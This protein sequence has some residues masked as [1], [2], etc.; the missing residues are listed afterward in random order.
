MR[1]LELGD[2][3]DTRSRR[4]AAGPLSFPRECERREHAEGF[5]NPGFLACQTRAGM[6]FVFVLAL[7]FSAAL[8]G[9]ITLAA[10]APAERMTGEVSGVRV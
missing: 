6:T 10:L 7:A 2:A 4:T 1:R 8:G 9:C 5:P 3:I